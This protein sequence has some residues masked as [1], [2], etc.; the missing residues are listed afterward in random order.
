MFRSIALTAATAALATAPIAAQ[1]APQRAPAPISAESER[2]GASPLL[3]ILGIALIVGL[4]IVATTG[5][6]DPVSP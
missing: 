1:A 6:D 5:G 4:I 2:L 3:I